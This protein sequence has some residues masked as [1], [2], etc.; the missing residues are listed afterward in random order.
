MLLHSSST[1]TTKRTRMTSLKALLALSLVGGCVASDEDIATGDDMELADADSAP[2]GS[3]KADAPGWETAATLHANT[4]QFDMV[5]PGSRRVH[6]LWVD[7]SPSS[8]VPLTITANAS[9]GFDV[10]IAVL[11]PVGANGARTTLAADGYSTR[12]RRASVALNLSTRG[13]HIVVV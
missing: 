8:K 6:S 9:E 7:G 13:E 12:K 1:S 11:G 3:A 5:G 4:K 2:L 10:R